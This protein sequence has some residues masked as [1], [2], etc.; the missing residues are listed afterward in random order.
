MMKLDVSV[1]EALAT[2]LNIATN[3]HKLAIGTNEEN[4]YLFRMNFIQKFSSDVIFLND[5][6]DNDVFYHRHADLIMRN[7]IEQLIEFLYVSKNEELINEYL[8]LSINLNEL[9]KK[10]VVES[11]KSFGGE[12]FTEKRTSIAKMAKDL[13]EYNVTK[14]TMTLYDVY[15]ILSEKCHNSYF[16]SLIDDFNSL[17]LGVSK[18][19][20][21]KEHIKL[22]HIMVACVLMEYPEK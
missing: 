14:G 13:G 3:E 1:I 22:I 11:E 16:S 15:A 4:K 2:V 17:S 7:M 18:S 20:L 21:T 12:R 6:S 9:S 10:S 5:L 19:G 8:G